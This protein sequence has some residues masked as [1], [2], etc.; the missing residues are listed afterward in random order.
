[1]KKLGVFLAVVISFLSC[2]VNF[3]SECY[4]GIYVRNVSDIPIKVCLIYGS[5]RGTY[6]L[7]AMRN[8]LDDSDK[9]FISPGESRYIE[10]VSEYVCLED[11]I[12]GQLS[13]P[14]SSIPFEL[15]PIYICDTAESPLAFYRTID[16]A[17]QSVNILKQISMLDSSLDDLKSSNFSFQYP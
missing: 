8:E 17:L 9:R 10:L 5:D 3:D 1:M 16:S 4:N 7:Y 14:R 2:D 6:T 11:E 13:R 12:E 15:R